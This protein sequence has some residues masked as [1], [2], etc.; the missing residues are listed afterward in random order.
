MQDEEA[1]M[2]VSAVTA[3]MAGLLWEE[4]SMDQ[5]QSRAEILTNFHGHWSILSFPE[6]K[7]P[8]DLIGPYGPILNS[9]GPMA[10][11]SL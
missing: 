5:C 11:K 8:R 7:A 9:H 2:T 3:A 4:L 1:T 10:P 6:N